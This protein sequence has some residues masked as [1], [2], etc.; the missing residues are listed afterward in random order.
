MY[1][2]L[3]VGVLC[4]SLFSYV[5]LDVL[6]SFAIVLTRKRELV[7]LLLLGFWFL[8]SVNGL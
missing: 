1:I 6:S 2:P 7:A 5:L 8:V 4:W 3:C